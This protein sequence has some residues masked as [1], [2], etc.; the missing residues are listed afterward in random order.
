MFA[1]VTNLS[2]NQP[3][4]LNAQENKGWLVGIS[5]PMF[6]E[7]C[8]KRTPAILRILSIDFS[9]N[10]LPPWSRTFEFSITTRNPLRCHVLWSKD[11]TTKIAGSW[12]HLRHT[13]P[14]PKYCKYFTISWT[15]C[16]ASSF[17]FKGKHAKEPLCESWATKAVSFKPSS[18]L[19]SSMLLPVEE[20]SKLKTGISRSRTRVGFVSC[21]SGFPFILTQASHQAA[22][23]VWV[24]MWSCTCSSEGGVAN[25]TATGFRNPSPRDVVASCVSSRIFCLSTVETKRFQSLILD[26][27]CDTAIYSQAALRTTIDESFVTST[28]AIVILSEDASTAMLVG[29]TGTSRGPL[30]GSET[31]TAALAISGFSLRFVVACWRAPP[32]SRCWSPPRPCTAPLV[33]APVISTSRCGG[34]LAD[35]PGKSGVTELFITIPKSTN[36]M[37]FL[38]SNV[39]NLLKPSSGASRSSSWK[40]LWQSSMTCHPCPSRYATVVRYGHSSM[41]WFFK[42]ST[43]CLACDEHKGK[44][45]F[46]LY[47]PFFKSRHA[48]GTSTSMT[49]TVSAII[50]TTPEISKE[51]C[52]K[53]NSTFAPEEWTKKDLPSSGTIPQPCLKSLP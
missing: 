15:A 22:Y 18:P 42:T 2:I 16:L 28:P 37:I 46:V 19:W 11:C 13:S 41:V 7:S 47:Q 43:K 48:F 45:S 51:F 31:G 30:E 1:F 34:A 5:W 27:D 29:I 9:A 35:E 40:T 53:L 20:K 4:C 12:S 25:C 52:L 39:I 8:L 10:A 36:E 44:P 21:R 3:A 26:P 14:C 17:P 23:G 50:L 33:D 6:V 49:L 32:T 38:D 24:N